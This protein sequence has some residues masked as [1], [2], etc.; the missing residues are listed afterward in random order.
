MSIITN[1][2]VCIHN[3]KYSYKC[4]YNCTYNYSYSRYTGKEYNYSYKSMYTQL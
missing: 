4:T 1:I 3:Y 2:Q